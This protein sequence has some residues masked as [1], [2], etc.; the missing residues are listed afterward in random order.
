MTVPHR[1][2][3][4]DVSFCPYIH[5]RCDEYGDYCEQCAILELF[6][7]TKVKK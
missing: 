2:M 7:E 4:E 1:A 3:L 6:E 5:I